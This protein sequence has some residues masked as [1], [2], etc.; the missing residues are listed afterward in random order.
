MGDLH[1]YLRTLP[2]DA[3][4]WGFWGVSGICHGIAAMLLLYI[5][6]PKAIVIGFCLSILLYLR[7]KAFGEA[8]KC[9]NR[10]GNAHPKYLDSIPLVKN[11]VMALE[12]AV[13]V[14]LYAFVMP[15]DRLVMPRL[16]PHVDGAIPKNAQVCKVPYPVLLV[17]GFLCN[18]I[19]MLP[20]R[21]FLGYHGVKPIYTMTLSPCLGDISE[22][23]KALSKKVRLQPF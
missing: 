21:I 3:L 19:F 18:S 2:L 20:I 4:L 14:S 10:W 9:K 6:V 15:F 1:S 16:E 5:G 11:L 13:F 7:A 8:L 22:Y 12:F 23:S 17:H